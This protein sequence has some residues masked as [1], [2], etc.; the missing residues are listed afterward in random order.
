M[1]L[2]SRLGVEKR[3]TTDN[4]TMLDV[5]WKLDICV[6]VEADLLCL[7]CVLQD[8]EHEVSAAQFCHVASCHPQALPWSA[9]ALRPDIESDLTESSACRCS[10]HYVFEHDLQVPDDD[11]FYSR[12][13]GPSFLW[14]VV[15]P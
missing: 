14:S 7:G 15:V 13:G 3:I 8:S 6:R 11:Y 4:H 2:E 1:I 12:V 9:R 10:V 5:D